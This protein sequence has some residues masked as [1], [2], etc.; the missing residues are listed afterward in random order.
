MFFSIHDPRRF[1]EPVLAA[2]LT[3]SSMLSGEALPSAQAFDES[4]ALKLVEPNKAD[5][6]RKTPVTREAMKQYLEDLKDRTP[7]IPLPELSEEETKQAQ[8]NPRQFGY[9]ARLRKFYLGDA[10]N[11]YLTFGGAPVGG[12]PNLQTPS[13][14]NPQDPALSLDYGFKVRM[15]WIAARANNCQYCLGHQ[16]SKLLEIGRAHV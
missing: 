3:V 15:F 6:P 1:R 5:Q 12:F 13:R 16:E 7:R 9:E 4:T 14:P 10:P 8:E 11:A 2:I